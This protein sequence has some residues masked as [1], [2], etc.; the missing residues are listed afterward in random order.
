MKFLNIQN[1]AVLKVFVIAKLI[2]MNV[3]D[4]DEANDF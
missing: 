3:W 2:T 4:V 1:E